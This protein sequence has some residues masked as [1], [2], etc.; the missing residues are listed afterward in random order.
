MTHPACWKVAFVGPTAVGKTSLIKAFLGETIEHVERTRGVDLYVFKRGETR[1]VVWDTAGQEWFHELVVR[2]LRGAHIVVLV[3]DLSRPDT[4]YEV[5][6]FW[7]A[8]IREHAPDDAYV[9]VVGN[10]KDIATIPK[11]VLDAFLAKLREKLD[12]KLFIPT[13]ALT[14]ENVEKLF[15]YIF[16]AAEAYRVLARMRG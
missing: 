6:N 4:M 16:R 13:S 12:F 1:V 7:A 8:A 10:K 14:G 5:L 2:F 3:F 9:I 11:H 15:S